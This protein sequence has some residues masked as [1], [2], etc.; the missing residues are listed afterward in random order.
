M[1]N[2]L[3]SGFSLWQTIEQAALEQHGFGSE[4]HL[5]CVDLDKPS[6]RP[7]ECYYELRKKND[8]NTPPVTGVVKYDPFIKG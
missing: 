3:K 2:G 8:K 6:S 7:G 4:W 5:T 1:S